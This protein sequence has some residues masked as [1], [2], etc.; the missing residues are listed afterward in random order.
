MQALDLLA[1]HSFIHTLKHS[2]MALEKKTVFIVAT[3]AV[4]IPT[5]VITLTLTCTVKLTFTWDFTN[6]IYSSFFWIFFNTKSGTT[7]HSC[8]SYSNS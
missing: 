2:R 8:L 1:Q 5:I 4:T 7:E 3:S 6:V